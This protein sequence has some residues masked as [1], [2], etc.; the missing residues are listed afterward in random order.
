M[1]YGLGLGIG[2]GQVNLHRLRV[3]YSQV[4]VW[5]ALPLPIRNPY[6]NRRSCGYQPGLDIGEGL[7][8]IGFL[9]CTGLKSLCPKYSIIRS[10]LFIQIYHYCHVHGLFLCKFNILFKLLRLNISH[11]NQIQ[12]ASRLL[13]PSVLWTMVTPYTFHAFT[14]RSHVGKDPVADH[15]AVIAKCPT[16]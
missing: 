5:V 14:M 15:E 1:S 7:Q 8:K 2:T 3:G 6:P 16:H 11:E 12:K 4:W 13:L 9:K 10:M